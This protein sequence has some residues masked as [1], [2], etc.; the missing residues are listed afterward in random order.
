MNG[1]LDS[2]VI[3]T[4]EIMKNEKSNHKLTGI[5][6]SGWCASPHNFTF[7]SHLASY[8]NRNICLLKRNRKQSLHF[9]RSPSKKLFLSS[10]QLVW[11][12]H[13]STHLKLSV[14]LNGICIRNE[15]TH[16][17]GKMSHSTLL[18]VLP[19]AYYANDFTLMYH[20]THELLTIDRNHL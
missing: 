3:G 20:S 9:E 5:F 7:T 8:A 16:D 2:D 17:R 19:N 14:P 1:L 18:Y 11:Q 6:A 13:S 4:M 15:L 10:F 12:A